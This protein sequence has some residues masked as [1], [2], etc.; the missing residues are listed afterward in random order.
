VSAHAGARAQVA[1]RSWAGASV[2]PPAPRRAVAGTL[3]SALMLER[4]SP[5]EPGLGYMVR[6][7]YHVEYPSRCTR[8]QCSRKSADAAFGH[9]RYSTNSVWMSTAACSGDA[10]TERSRGTPC[11]AAGLP[12]GRR[13]GRGPP[14]VQTAGA[15]CRRCSGCG[16][17]PRASRGPHLSV[18]ATPRARF[19]GSLGLWASDAGPLTCMHA[20]ADSHTRSDSAAKAA[21]IS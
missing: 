13:W 1:S 17:L 21:L 2:R 19:T 6:L 18:P 7:T 11:A 4:L 12:A 3:P 20:A 9:K 16:C 10:R 8:Q 14:G 5:L 15:Q